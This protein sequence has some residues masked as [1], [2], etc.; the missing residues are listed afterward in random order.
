[1]YVRNRA[2]EIRPDM[3]FHRL[4][5][6]SSLDFIITAQRFIHPK[7][8]IIRAEIHAIPSLSPFV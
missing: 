3:M 8:I 7:M 5:A 6:R 2:P 4:F 1:M